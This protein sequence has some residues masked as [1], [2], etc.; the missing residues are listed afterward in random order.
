MND[1]D[2]VIVGIG[3]AGETA[4]GMLRAA[5]KTVAIIDHGPVGG[6]CALRGCQPKKVFVVN[7][8]LVAG[9]RAL[10]A[11]GVGSAATIDWASLQRFKRT[12][13]DPIPE[14]TKESLQMRGIDVFVERASLTGPQTVLLENSARELRAS[15]V[16]IATGARSRPLPIPGAELAATSDDFLELDALPSSMVFIGGGY[17]S[18]EFAFMAALA[19]SQVTILQRGSHL[20]PQLPSTLV[21]PVVQA[22]EK[23][24]ISF[25]TD[26][27]VTGISRAE[28]GLA[29]TTADQGTFN[30]AWVMG[31]IG[32]VPNVENLGLEAAGV[33]ATGRGI[34]VNEY[35]ETSVAGVF[36]IGDCA[37]TKQ[38]APIGDMEARVAAANILSS[39]VRRADY[40]RV[41]S[42][43][44]TH[45][46]MASVGLTSAEAQSSGHEVTVTSGRGD[47]WPSSRRLGGAIVYYETVTDS[48]SG[49][50]LGASIT[51]PYAGEQINL[52]TAAIRSGMTADEFRETPWAYPTYTSDL[53]YMV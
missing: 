43:V 42:V 6:T 13:T 23:Y 21:D 25:V 35:M 24:G 12:F 26:V 32:R 16:I 15:H 47:G 51:S 28:G 41:P 30:A 27:S 2:V 10:A 34:E 39:H 38:L 8:H 50:L 20:L 31:A 5:G 53:K 52:F 37:A 17:I 22:G 29:V 48:V 18:L 14:S 1:Y 19:G 44:F 9:T 46:Q 45:P 36:A 7:T 49:K 3:T 11:K 4:A 40:N 33:R